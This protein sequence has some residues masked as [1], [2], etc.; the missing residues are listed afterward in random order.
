MTGMSTEEV[1]LWKLEQSRYRVNSIERYHQ[2]GLTKLLLF[3]QYD[4]VLAG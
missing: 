3:L 1:V 2:I 4:V